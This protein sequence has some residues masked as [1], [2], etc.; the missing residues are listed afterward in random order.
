VVRYGVRIVHFQY[1]VPGFTPLRTWLRILRV[2]FLVTFH[3][4]DVHQAA[5]GSEAAEGI[6]SLVR[7]ANL[8]TVT[9]DGLLRD[10]VER[11]PHARETAEVIPNG[12]PIDIWD[13]AAE[14][15]SCVPRDIDVLF[16]GNLR[17]VKGPD[18][19]VEAFRV[20]VTLRP[21][22]S[23]VFVGCGDMDEQLRLGVREA[24]LEAH[25][26]F[27]GRAGRKDIAGYYRRARVLAVPSRAEGFSLVAAEAQLFGVPVVATSVGGLPQTICDGETGS[28][29]AFGD[30]VGFAAAC[31][32]LLDDEERWVRSS[33]SARTWAH[34]HFS[35]DVMA[36]RFADLYERVLR[37]SHR[38]NGSEAEI[39]GLYRTGSVNTPDSEVGV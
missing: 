18:F 19:L 28:L 25:V 34:A 29:V 3:G 20:L 12:I 7:S 30:T 11:S 1:A 9:S 36:G 8:V 38:S 35:P 16:V 27:A 24:G 26:T 32:D 10:L 2:P 17:I 21:S 22:T 15:D 5:L 31:R 37:V 6:D 39:G 4:S 13:L 33:S 14:P 23:L